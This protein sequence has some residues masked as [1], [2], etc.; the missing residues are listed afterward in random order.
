MSVPD[1]L[2]FESLSDEELEQHNQALQAQRTAI[3]EEQDALVAVRNRRTNEAQ[4][5]AKLEGLDESG[6][7][8]LI[9]AATAKLSAGAPTPDE[10][11]K[12]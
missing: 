6:L 4:A 5:A 7:N 1:Y 11:A 3:G 10:E 2:D 9:E 8:V 12:G